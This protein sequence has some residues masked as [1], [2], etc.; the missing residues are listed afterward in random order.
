MANILYFSTSWCGPCKMFKPVVQEVSQQTGKPVQFID[1]Q[2]NQ[3]MAAKYG[4]TSVP[5]IIIESG[6]GTAKHVGP[7]PKAKLVELFSN[8]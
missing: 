3:E 5:T 7:Q 6:H 4:V 8:C 2:Q 1:A